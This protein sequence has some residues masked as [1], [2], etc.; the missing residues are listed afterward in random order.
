MALEAL[1]KDAERCTR[2]AY[3]KWIPFDLVKSWRFSKGCPSIEYGKF[4]SYSA[5]GRLVTALSL[6]EGRSTVTDKVV[7]SVFK[8]T[9]CGQCDVSCKICRY[10]MEPLAD[11]RELRQS[12][13]EMGHEL[14]QLKKVV[15]TARQEHNMLGKPKAQRGDWAAE[16]KVKNLDKEKAEFVFHAGCRYSFD[17]DLGHVARTAVRILQKAGIDVG[18]MGSDEGCCGGRAYDMG[19]RKSLGGCAD[20]N[21]KKWQAAGV[22]TVITPCAN[23]Y[24]TFKRLYPAEAGSTIK[25]FHIVECIDQL[26][27]AG[28]L[29]FTKPVA[30]KVTYHDPC[31]LGRQGEEYV[32]WN[33]KEKKIFGQAVAYDPPRPRYNGA[34]GVYQPPR[35]VL[36][37]IPGVELVEMERIKEAAWCCGGGGGAPEAYPEFSSWTATER[38]EEAK[39]TGADAIVTACPWCERNFLDVTKNNGTKMKV[40]DVLELV[41]QAI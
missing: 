4:H 34:F 30:M 13:V 39:S 29:K 9:L 37:A 36:T 22:K 17:G 27:K 1:R 18:I 8:C 38:M 32:P 21:L 14:P 20:G 7:D 15:E 25:V 12:L 10:D 24:F 19:Y 28:Q 40:L 23:C 2:C 11:M 16:L 26:I 6:M 3:C 31:H 5:G 33:G 35:D 41:E